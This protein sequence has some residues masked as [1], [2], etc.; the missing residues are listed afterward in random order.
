MKKI[1]FFA[2]FVL[3]ALAPFGASAATFESGESYTLPM[4]EVITDDLFIGS[5][6]VQIDGRVEGD[7]FIGSSI[8]DITGDITGSVIIGAS[9]VTIS[10]A[11]GNDLYVGAGT[12]RLSGPVEDNVYI[13][14]G[15][16]TTKNTF[17][18]KNDVFIGSGDAQIDGQIGKNLVAGT[19]ALDIL[20]RVNNSAYVSSGESNSGESKRSGLRVSQDAQIGD[21]LEYQSQKEAAI[22]SAAQIGGETV[23][24]EAQKDGVASSKNGI[25]FN[26][27]SFSPIAKILS[28]MSGFLWLLMIT[29]LFVAVAKEKVEML[30]A[31]YQEN[32]GKTL[33]YGSLVGFLLLI[34]T[35]IVLLV[36]IVTIIGIPFAFILGLL[37]GI[38]LILSKAITAIVI[39][40]LVFG[41]KVGTRKK[42]LYLTASVGVLI[43]SVATAIPFIG[44]VLSIV[45]T[46]FGLGAIVLHM[47]KARQ[48]KKG[49]YQNTVVEK[50]MAKK[51][52]YQEKSTDSKK[53]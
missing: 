50:D 25:N 35:P 30:T 34:T 18:S 49:N 23:F 17:S 48:V 8:V 53:K 45:A 1:A 13:G 31:V 11:V 42:S 15:V 29:L 44:G 43:L 22:S 39:G 47:M 32:L 14:S 26:F 40:D 24:T 37:Y 9:Y 36:L 4:G 3:L 46:I 52:V 21:N 19:G 10:G 38:V 20:G 2:A 7:V 16:L 6:R 51:E 5:E 41:E 33:G 28:W 12:V 27:N